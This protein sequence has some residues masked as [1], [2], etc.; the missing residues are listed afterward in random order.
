MARN[1]R[2]RAVQEFGLDSLASRFEEL[3]ERFGA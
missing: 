3:Y 1:C 2:A